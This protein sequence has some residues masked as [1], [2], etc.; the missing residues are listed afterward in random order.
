MA[1]LN[2]TEIDLKEGF[3]LL[4]FGQ[5]LVGAS[6]LKDG[7]GIKLDLYF[8]E[9]QILQS[10]ALSYGLGNLLYSPALLLAG[11]IGVALN[12]RGLLG[13]ATKIANTLPWSISGC[14]E[15][16]QFCFEVK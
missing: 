10:T 11:C 1:K 6:P 15:P 9:W 8:S 2:D 13:E 12:P 14:D 3:G 5:T 7:R 16:Y 4:E